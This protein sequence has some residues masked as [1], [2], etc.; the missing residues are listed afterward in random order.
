MISHYLTP[1]HYQTSK[2][3]KAL[4]AESKTSP[5]KQNLNVHYY[6][7]TLT[8]VVKIFKIAFKILIYPERRCNLSE[9]LSTQY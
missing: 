7:Y 6:Y 3:R 8:L 5:E 1:L 2:P 9:E 4:V